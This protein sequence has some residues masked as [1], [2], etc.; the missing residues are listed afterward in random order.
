MVARCNN[1]AK[2]KKVTCLQKATCRKEEWHKVDGNP[3]SSNKL[4][5]RTAETREYLQSGR[6][7]QPATLSCPPSASFQPERLFQ[8]AVLRG[9]V[10]GTERAR[11]CFRQLRLLPGHVAGEV[12]DLVTAA[13]TGRPL[14]ARHSP[15]QDAAERS[16]RRRLP[17]QRHRPACAR[18]VRR[19]VS[20][21]P[22]RWTLWSGS[23]SRHCYGN[24]C[25]G[26]SPPRRRL[27][28]APKWVPMATPLT[29]P[30]LLSGCPSRFLISPVP[31]C[32]AYSPPASLVWSI[33]FPS[34]CWFMHPWV[35]FALRVHLG[36]WSKLVR[37]DLLET[38]PE[39]NLL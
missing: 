16:C 39:L 18:L 21:G 14:T 31:G 1:C 37:L 23:S 25:P 3:P 8:G 35:S 5:A 27:T 11:R 32:C 38:Q 10:G 24:R 6:S 9:W 28:A 26:V 17:F 19:M 30:F 13:G 36:L 34:K 12:F 33:S 4:R 7:L 20:V 22:E 15:A 2:K 29:L